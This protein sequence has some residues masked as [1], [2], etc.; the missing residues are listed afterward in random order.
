MSET[1]DF[2]T[3]SELICGILRLC[4]FQHFFRARPSAGEIE[5]FVCSEDPV[6]LLPRTE[7]AQEGYWMESERCWHALQTDTG[8]IQTIMTR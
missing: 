6:Y 2:S 5:C 8:D 1:T 3:R 7:T 4:F